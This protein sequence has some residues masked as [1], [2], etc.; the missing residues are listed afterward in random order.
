MEKTDFEKPPGYEYL[1]QIYRDR[2]EEK[3]IRF[4]QAEKT[5]SE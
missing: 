2:E 3:R 1:E 5:R 4:E